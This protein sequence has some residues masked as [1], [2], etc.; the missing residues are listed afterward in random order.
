MA[1]E[2]AGTGSAPVKNKIVFKRRPVKVIARKRGIPRNDTD[3]DEDYSSQD[4]SGERVVKRRR[5]GGVKMADATESRTDTADHKATTFSADRTAAIEKSSDA[6]KQ[7]NWYDEDKPDAKSLLGTTRKRPEDT[8]TA[9]DGTYKGKAAYSSFIQKNPDKYVD[10]FN[11]VGPIKA[12]SNVRTI[13]ITDY[14]PDVCK[15][16]KQTG[17][18]GFGDSCKFLH[19]REDYKAGWALDREWE[20]KTGGKKQEGRVVSSI[21]KT[22]DE[23]EDEKD[24]QLLESIPFACVICKE[25]YKKPIT[26]RC[27][28]YFCQGCAMK[29][30]RKDPTCAVCGAATGGIFN[31]AR[32]LNELLERKKAREERIKANEE[33][34]EAEKE[35]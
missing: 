6:T 3:S 7:S 20:I 29:R 30:F 33:A 35:G 34:K 12:S 31:T 17:F 22:Q 1:S 11:R 24:A 5:K 4:E 9:P 27:S 14:A 16:Y 28:H 8:S 2:T 25:P 26:T 23:L 10:K 19:A 32:K 15:D 18:C 13:T 21:N